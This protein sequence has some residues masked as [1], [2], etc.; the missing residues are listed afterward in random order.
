MSFK[1]LTLFTLPCPD[2][3]SSISPFSVPI[4]KFTPHKAAHRISELK[5][6]LY[7]RISGVSLVMSCDVGVTFTLT[8]LSRR[9][10]SEPPAPNPNV[11]KLLCF[12]EKKI[13]GLYLR[14]IFRQIFFAVETYFF[15]GFIMARWCCWRSLTQKIG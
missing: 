8:W 7:L 6:F 5:R 15:A 10:G 14:G 3:S 9:D 11:K 4:S 1:Q 2:R 12:Y 13:F